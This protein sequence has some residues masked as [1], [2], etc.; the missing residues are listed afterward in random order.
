MF[1]HFQHWI[2]IA[3]FLLCGRADAQDLSL[4]LLGGVLNY[5]GDLRQ[6]VYTFQGVRLGY[7][8]GITYDLTPRL[9][10]GVQF[11]HGRIAADD[12]NNT[13]PGLFY[14]NLNFT[15]NVSEV[16]LN[17]TIHL[18]DPL[19]VR[20]S[21]YF[22]GGI[23]FFRFNPFTKDLDRN[24][25]Y[26][27]PL[28][29]EGQGLSGYPLK[30]YKLS[31]YSIPFGGGITFRLSERTSL[32]WEVVFRRT[33]TDHLDDVSTV[34]ADQIDLLIGRGPKAVEL[35]FRGDELPGSNPVFPNGYPDGGKRGNPNAKDWY[36]FS[37]LKLSVRLPSA[38][39]PVV[40]NTGKSRTDC[41]R[42]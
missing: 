18:L 12:K 42:W 30:P 31:Q 33:G 21:P 14:R 5:Q 4:H 25:I 11:T 34:Y 23:A 39:K 37:G 3:S 29:T 20:I 19:R 27:Q 35:A 10:A 32:A 22:T 13:D 17:A 38:Q 15:T 7:G 28:G 2:L 8:L 41:P 36:Y 16:S 24:K 40:G 1:R 9:T 6:E 26:L